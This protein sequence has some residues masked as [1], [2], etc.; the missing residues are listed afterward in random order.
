MKYVI[1]IV[2]TLLIICIGF[3]L[4]FIIALDGV[5][6]S[7]FKTEILVAKNNPDKLYI[8][9]ESWGLTGDNQITIIS[10]D[11]TR[12]FEADSTKDFVF[13]G[14]SPFL[15]KTSQDTLF[16]YT[17]K[18]VDNPHNFKSSWK[19]IQKEVAN[20]EYMDLIADHSYKRI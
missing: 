4:V 17:M 11:G 1:I 10:T 9:S 2:T 18:K 14:L 7:V 8:K 12:K 5:G 15:Y 13:K 19:I 16:L 6:D 20:V 3:C